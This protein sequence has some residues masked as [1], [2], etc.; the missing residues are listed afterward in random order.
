MAAPGAGTEIDRLRRMFGGFAV[1]VA[2]PSWALV[3]FVFGQPR[4]F[5]W[6]GAIG[7]AALAGV[8]LHAV[9]APRHRHADHA[10][11]SV[12]LAMVC[13]SHPTPAACLAVVL[14]AVFVRAF[15]ARGAAAAL[16]VPLYAGI[17]AAALARADRPFNVESVSTVGAVVVVGVL[18]AILDRI[19]AAQVRHLD[20]TTAVAVAATKLAA[21]QDRHDTVAIVTEAIRGLLHDRHATIAIQM[22]RK[23]PD[24]SETHS[25]E[26]VGAVSFPIGGDGCLL[27]SST[28][29]IGDA[30]DAITLLAV[31]LSLAIQRYRATRKAARAQEELHRRELHARDAQRLEALGRLAGGIAHDFNNVLA[32]IRTIA[33][34][35]LMDAPDPSSPDAKDFEDILAAAERGQALTNRILKIGRREQTTIAIGGVT[36]AVAVLLETAAFVRRSTDPA[37]AIVDELAA[38]PNRL[39]CEKIHLEQIVTNLLLN[40]RDACNGKGTVRLRCWSA[41]GGGGAMLEVS[42]D[43]AGMNDEVQQRMYEPFFTT[44]GV[45]RGTGL[46]LS[47]VQALV[48]QLQGEIAVESA[49][50]HGTTFRIYLP[51]V[52]ETSKP[53]RTARPAL[54]AQR[55]GLR[56]LVVDDEPS[57]R[58]AVRRILEY[59]GYL[60]TT[61]SGGAEALEALAAGHQFDVVL[62]DVMMPDMNGRQL[63]DALVARWPA[64]PVIFM[65]GF[66][67]LGAATEASNVLA[68]PFS[69]DALVKHVRRSLVERPTSQH[70]MRAVTEIAHPT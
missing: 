26:E 23:D 8:W 13:F 19:M 12:A 21:V 20:R 6:V 44:K 41:P 46:G 60:V 16:T 5:Q 57:V 59:R 15:I 51:Y 66:E 11:A 33:E 17:V 1:A 69:A 31:A 64:L 55:T 62:S 40:A 27:I 61:A 58:D 49:L 18:A 36:D 29:P 52:D 37:I 9:Y 28:R 56:V 43:G 7:I 3:V 67:D 22:R 2:L 25:I 42:D 70:H 47:T 39:R 10:L 4:P 63:A 45:A 54:G 24:S 30:E 38:L 50:G 14:P 48:E 32:G 53:R 35:R 68:K 65:S 34:L